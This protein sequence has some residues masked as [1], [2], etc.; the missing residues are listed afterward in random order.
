[1]YGFSQG[2]VLGPLLFNI[3]MIDLVLERED[4]IN[5]HW[6]DTASYSWAED[7]KDVM[8]SVITELQKLPTKFS[9]GLRIIL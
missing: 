3:D 6:D 9:G 4:N 5:S 2:L 8:S 7:I 1:M